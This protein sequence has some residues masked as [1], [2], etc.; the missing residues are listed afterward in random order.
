MHITGKRVLGRGNGKGQGPE[1]GESRKRKE[2][3]EAGAQ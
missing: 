1:A 2:D 3:G